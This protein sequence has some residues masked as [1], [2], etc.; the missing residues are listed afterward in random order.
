MTPFYQTL[1]SVR[2]GRTFNNNRKKVERKLQKVYLHFGSYEVCI[3]FD[4]VFNLFLCHTTHTSHKP[5]LRYSGLLRRPTLF[6]LKF[7][8]RAIWTKLVESRKR[9]KREINEWKIQSNGIVLAQYKNQT[10]GRVTC[11]YMLLKDFLYAFSSESGSF[12]IFTK[13]ISAN[14]PHQKKWNVNNERERERE[15]CMNKMQMKIFDQDCLIKFGSSGLAF[16]AQLSL[17]RRRAQPLFLLIQK[18]QNIV[19]LNWIIRKRR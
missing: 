4:C 13:E 16:S 14:F 10:N 1:F 6:Q 2:S 17:P 18:P 15:I 11:N 3:Q 5:M 19:I 12:G 8:G 7:F 9:K